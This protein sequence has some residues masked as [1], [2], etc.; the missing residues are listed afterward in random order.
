MVFFAISSVICG[1]MA[2]SAALR[3]DAQEGDLLSSSDPGSLLSVYLAASIGDPLRIEEAG[4]EL[5][6]R[7]TF[8]EVLSVLGWMAADGLPIEAFGPVLAV[9]GEVVSGLCQPWS[10]FLSVSSDAAGV[11]TVLMTFGGE[12]SG[13]SDAASAAQ[14]IGWRDGDSLTA[15]LVL[16][17]PLLPHGGEV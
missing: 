14:N 13:S 17:P 3:G 1:V 8:G 4:V 12:P 10:A 16:S 7:E 5:T 9:C 15:T 2:S 11:R 6:G